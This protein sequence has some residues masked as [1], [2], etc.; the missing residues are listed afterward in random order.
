MCG[1]GLNVPQLLPVATAES[2]R[3]PVKYGFDVFSYLRL[4]VWVT[5]HSPCWDNAVHTE[6][7]VV[8]N[9]L[10]K[11]INVLLMWLTE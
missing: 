2:P 5:K 9:A 1:Q 6:I 11:P 7:C 4:V 10:S 8:C 3:L